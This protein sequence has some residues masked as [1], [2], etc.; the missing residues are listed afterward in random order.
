MSNG[1][2]IKL[3]VVGLPIEL[4]S[5]VLKA[6]SA[7]FSEAKVRCD[8]DGELSIILKEEVI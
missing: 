4:V 1:W 2:M 7:E 6:I 3:N 8:K 5:R